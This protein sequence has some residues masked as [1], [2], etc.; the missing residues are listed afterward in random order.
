[1]MRMLALA[2]VVVG[3]SGSTGGVVGGNVPQEQYNTE[4]C[5]AICAHYAS[6]GIAQFDYYQSALGAYGTVGTNFY[7]KA[8]ELRKIKYDGAAAA[9]CLSG[10]SSSACALNAQLTT[11]ADCRAIY[12]GQ[13][14]VGSACGYGLVVISGTCSQPPQEGS[15]CSTA[16]LIGSCAPGLACAS[17]SKTC[18]KPKVEGDSCSTTAPCDTYFS[19]VSG[20]CTRPGD[21]GAS[22]GPGRRVGARLQARALLQCLRQQRHLRAAARRR[23]HLQ[24][25]RVR[26]RPALQQGDCGR[27]RQDLSQADPAQRGLHACDGQ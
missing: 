13:V 21:V 20:K 10:Y 14:P 25:L 12:V 27:N 2:L 23:Q 18:V 16:T 1:M 3:C 15:S 24:G 9:R 8:I 11:D 7:D 19:C 6:C 5:K 17:D 22:C 26:L 4:G